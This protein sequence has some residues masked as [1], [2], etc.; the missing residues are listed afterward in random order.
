MGNRLGT[1]AL[2]LVIGVVFGAIG[3]VAHTTS[4][5]VAGIDI[6]IGLI[7]SVVAVVSLLVGL[8]LVIHDKLVVGACA[9]GL[10]GIVALFTLPSAGGS[11][12]I[13][14]GIASVIWTV[15]P[16][17]TAALVLAWPSL[18]PRAGHQHR[19]DA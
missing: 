1:A 15:T 5:T 19:A 12:L 9:V 3:T 17:F 10:I 8:R 7:L 14:Q 2:A 11:V 6:P 13:P 4:V 16:A 18:P